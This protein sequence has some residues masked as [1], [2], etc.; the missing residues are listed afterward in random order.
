MAY[1]T[2]STLLFAGKEEALRELQVL[3][4]KVVFN[5]YTLSLS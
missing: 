1:Q 2:D 3:K 4:P 5:Y